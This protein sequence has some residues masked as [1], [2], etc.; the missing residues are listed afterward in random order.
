MPG[1]EAGGQCRVG[2]SSHAQAG[3]LSGGRGFWGP[4]PTAPRSS[5]KAGFSTGLPRPG[6]FWEEAEGGRLGVLCRASGAAHGGLA[7][8][9]FS[10]KLDLRGDSVTNSSVVLACEHA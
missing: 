6:L 8:T 7:L 10:G 2:E 1:A 5:E 3:R 9:D 4:E